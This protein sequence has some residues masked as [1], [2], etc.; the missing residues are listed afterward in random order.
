M[1]TVWQYVCDHWTVLAGVG[2]LMLFSEMRWHLT[3]H[4]VPKCRHRW[5][6]TG[7]FYHGTADG[8]QEFYSR[9]CEKCMRVEAKRFAGDDW[10]DKDTLL[11]LWSIKK[12]D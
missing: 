11:H 4:R 7:L 5:H 10:C 6:T 9:T 2:A 12:G 3:K 1:A 8:R